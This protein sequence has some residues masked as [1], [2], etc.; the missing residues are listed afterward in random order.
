MTIIAITAAVVSN[1][2]APTIVS[3]NSAIIFAAPS[4]VV[5]QALAPIVMSADTLL[6]I[7]PTSKIT[8]NAYA[9]FIVTNEYRNKTINS[10][11]S[12]MFGAVVQS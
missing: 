6:I 3:G 9:R 7:A 10:E 12:I 8:V 5:A 4:T 2:P 1:V 11:I